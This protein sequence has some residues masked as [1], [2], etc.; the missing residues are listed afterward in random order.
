MNE[1]LSEEM[2]DCKDE[3]LDGGSLTYSEWRMENGEWI[4]A[5][6]KKAKDCR[7]ETK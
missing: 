7:P 2:T 6:I 4:T 5:N 1:W 3:L